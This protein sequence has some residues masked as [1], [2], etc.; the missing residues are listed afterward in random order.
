MGALVFLR[1]ACSWIEYPA[2]SY[3]LVTILMETIIILMIREEVIWN[4]PQNRWVIHKGDRAGSIL[5]GTQG[6]SRDGQ[7][8]LRGEIRI[9][10]GPY[11]SQIASG[12]QKLCDDTKGL[13]RKVWIWTKILSPNRRYFILILRFVAI[14]AFFGNLWTK[15]VFFWAR[16]ALLHGIYCILYWVEFA[17]LQVR[18]K[19]TVLRENSKYALE[20]S[21]YGHLCPLW[22]AANFCHPGQHQLLLVEAHTPTRQHQ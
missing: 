5:R 8:R 12:W 7:Q 15:S 6:W 11:Q 9:S 18:A 13:R 21:F 10:W 3:C 16:S 14:H 2:H 19:T 17:K 20:E 22:K 4:N 1:G